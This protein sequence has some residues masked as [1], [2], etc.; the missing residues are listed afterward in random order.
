MKTAP[1]YAPEYPFPAYA[2]IPGKLPHPHRS[3]EGHSYGKEEP[4]ADR[5]DPARWS[6]NRL[7]LHG[8]DLFNHGYYWE[9]HEAWEGIWHTTGH[10]TH[11]GRFLKALIQFTAIGVK[12]LEGKLPG[13]RSLCRLSRRGFVSLS[14]EMMPEEGRYLGLGLGELVRLTHQIDEQSK[15]APGASRAILNYALKPSFPEDT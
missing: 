9:A 8:I 3:P 15:T 2:F 12:A 4:A 7:Y 6:E 13:V 5:I 10:D 11:P 1:R 14:L